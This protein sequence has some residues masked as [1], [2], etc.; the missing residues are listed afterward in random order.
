MDWQTE[1]TRSAIDPACTKVGRTGTVFL[2]GDS[3]AQAL[4]S[5]LRALLAPG[6]QLAQVAT[7]ACPPRLHEPQPAPL[8]G[9]CDV[10]NGHAR[11]RIAAIKPEV[12]VL[13]QIMGHQ[14]TDWVAMARALRAQGAQ[15]VILVGPMPQWLP[16]LPA[17][18][19]NHYWQQDVSRVSRG[20]N[21]EPF[22][23][24]AS[25]RTQLADSSE[26]EYAALNGALCNESGCLAALPGHDR[27][28]LVVDS[29]HLSPLGS[30]YVA[31]NILRSYLSDRGS[32]PFLPAPVVLAPVL[33]AAPMAA[34]RSSRR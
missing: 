23:L 11:T 17:V 22:T 14:A 31:E 34:A 7:S 13:A 20:L 33:P 29:S 3:H 5:G 27:Q 10:A 2:W 18:V 9:R 30:R 26:I 8:G 4:S 24:D 16:S 25:L 19:V 32:A 6:E 21:A 28:L 12:V 1:H 15:R